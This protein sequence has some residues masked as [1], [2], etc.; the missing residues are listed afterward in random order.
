MG[1]AGMGL[2][3]YAPLRPNIPDRRA[4][5]S[6]YQDPAM[7]LCAVKWPKGCKEEPQCRRPWREWKPP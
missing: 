4:R 3:T 1:Q 2:I 7:R 6:A 5:L